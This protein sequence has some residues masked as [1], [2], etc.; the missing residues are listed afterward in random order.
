MM[1]K[2]SL[3]HL[4]RKCAV[5]GRSPIGTNE[6]LYMRRAW[7][8]S[9]SPPGPQR[10]VPQYTIFGEKTMLSFK[11]I[12][13]TLR[14]LRNGALVVDSNKKG[15]ILLEWAP[16]NDGG[17]YKCG[18]IQRYRFVGGVD[19][20]SDQRSLDMRYRSYRFSRNVT[21]PSWMARNPL[22]RDNFLT[23]IFALLLDGN[24][25]DFYAG[26]LHNVVD[27]NHWNAAFIRPIILTGGYDRESQ[28]RFGLSAEEVGFILHQLPANTVEFARRLPAETPG[29]TA[30]LPEKLFTITPA[31]GGQFAFKI[32]FVKDGMGGQNPGS[33]TEALGPLEVVAQLGEYAVVREIFQKS[34][35]S[36]IGWD[37]QLNFA[38]QNAINLAL[39]GAATN[40]SNS[41]AATGGRHPKST[42][43]SDDAADLPF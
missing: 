5:A 10:S 27:W 19:C 34:I 41:G 24:V 8:S 2:S 29:V 9:V 38:M 18:Y 7:F 17:E 42:A 39:Q 6:V 37:V 22:S 40:N 31:E 14:C 43:S 16:R 28:I 36:L 4:L 15:R 23:K 13:P 35:P 25:P 20:V 33:T 12:P 11:V 21:G 3:S 32:D 26:Q 1:N 30:D